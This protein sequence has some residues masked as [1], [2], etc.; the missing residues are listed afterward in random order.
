MDMTTDILTWVVSYFLFHENYN[1]D[2][3]LAVCERLEP[4]HP[5]VVSLFVCFQRVLRTTMS[6][7]C[8][9]FQKVIGYGFLVGHQAT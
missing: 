1:S 4:R 9:T 2:F 5:L 6:D 3:L 7:D 8:Q